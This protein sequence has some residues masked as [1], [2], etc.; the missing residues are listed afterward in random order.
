MK[1][2]MM[3][4]LY[5]LIWNFLLLILFYQNSMYLWRSN[6]EIVNLNTFGATS[7]WDNYHTIR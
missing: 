7:S 1:P 5:S 4:L 6:S 2:I 3:N